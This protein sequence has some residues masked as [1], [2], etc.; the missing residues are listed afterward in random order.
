MDRAG[1]K[2]FR[3]SASSGNAQ[4]PRSNNKGMINLQEAN[5]TYNSPTF[6][7]AKLASKSLNK[8]S[9]TFCLP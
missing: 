7:R 9:V 3:V 6:Q 4:R 8:N 1:A 2:V 5:I